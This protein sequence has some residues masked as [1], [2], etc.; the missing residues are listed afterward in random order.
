MNDD[1][2]THKVAIIVDRQ[3]A[4]DSLNDIAKSMHVWLIS[5]SIN[6]K[7]SNE[8]YQEYLSESDDLLSD[9]ITMFEADE[10][11]SAE[12]VLDGILDEVDEHHNEYSHSPRWNELYVYGACLSENLR[13]ILN[14][15]G[16]SNFQEV[17]PSSFIAKCVN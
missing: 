10:L 4:K 3:F 2:L 14:E 1:N 17:S 13:S 5:S 11:L 16:F 6:L 7:N 12:H 8:F 15:F 9:G